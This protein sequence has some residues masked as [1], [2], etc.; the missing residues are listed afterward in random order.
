MIKLSY[1]LCRQTGEVQNVLLLY[2]TNI[3]T[4]TW[5]ICETKLNSDFRSTKNSLLTWKASS[6]N[7]MPPGSAL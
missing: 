2:T 5:I 4:Q 3:L 6:I 7:T 1:A